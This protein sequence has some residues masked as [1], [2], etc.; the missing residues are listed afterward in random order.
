MTVARDLLSPVVL[1]VDDF[2]SRDDW[3]GVLAEFGTRWRVIV[4]AKCR[5][6]VLQELRCDGVSLCWRAA[7]RALVWNPVTCRRER[8]FVAT[9]ARY[10]RLVPGLAEFSATLPVKAADAFPGMAFSACGRSLLIWP[11]K[12]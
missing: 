8:S 9:V 7:P 11:D 1:S 10:A 3:P 2:P 4:D 6:I 12:V 5:H